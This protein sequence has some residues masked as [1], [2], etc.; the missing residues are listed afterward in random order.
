MIDRNYINTIPTP[1]TNILHNS[2]DYDLTKLLYNPY[3]EN[4]LNNRILNSNLSAINVVK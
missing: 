2:V 4:E 1:T 3:S